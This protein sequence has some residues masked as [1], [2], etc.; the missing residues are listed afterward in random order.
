MVDANGTGVGQLFTVTYPNGYDIIVRQIS[1]TWV[2]LLVDVEVGFVQI[3]NAAAPFLGDFTYYF[4]S[5]DCTGQAYL[6]PNLLALD[7]SRAASLP[8][9]G[10]VA[11]IPP[12]T[13]PSIYFAGLPVSRL[14]SGSWRNAGAQGPGTSNTICNSNTFISIY[15]GPAQSVP[16]SSLGLTPPFSIK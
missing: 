6:V 4:Q 8:A 1:G 10:I 3:Q 7:Y 12:S 11:T 9:L 2:Q 5:V 16:L 15:V 14:N 13:Q